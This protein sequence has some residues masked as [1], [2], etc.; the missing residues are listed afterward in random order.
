M[1]CILGSALEACL[2]EYAIGPEKVVCL[3]FWARDAANREL[4]QFGEDLHYLHGGYGSMFEKIETALEHA[5][6]GER[7]EITIAP[8]EG[9]GKRDESG[10]ITQRKDSIPAEAWEPG[11]VLMGA[12]PDGREVPF[13]VV[14][15][16]DEMITLDCNHPWAGKHLHFTFEVMS[17][18]DSTE[19]ERR[20]GYVLSA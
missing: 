7:V 16:G 11:F 15:V 3:R 14:A 18:R 20:A 12:M 4:L 1:S 9:Y 8:E 17:I 10:V 19:G 6:C 13:T 5:L 2:D